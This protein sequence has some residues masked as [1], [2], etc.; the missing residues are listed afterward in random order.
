MSLLRTVVGVGAALIA[1]LTD[2]RVSKDLSVGAKR[3]IT[4]YVI[5]FN[6][7][8]YK[9]HNFSITSLK[10]ISLYSE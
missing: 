7:G 6:L 4:D 10:N 8:L 2:A 3:P 1:A 5:V 9:S